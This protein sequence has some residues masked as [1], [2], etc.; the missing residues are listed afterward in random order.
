MATEE[1]VLTMS[2]FGVE[3][4]RISKADRNRSLTPAAVAAGA[5]VGGLA[6]ISAGRTAAT[7]DALQQARA[8]QQDA[9]DIRQMA[10][11]KNRTA[12]E[13]GRRG[14]RFVGIVGENRSAA[15]VLH[16]IARRGDAAAAP[17]L[18]EVK[19]L[20]RISSN[21]AAGGAAIGALGAGIGSALYNHNKKK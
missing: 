19:R 7:R 3:D 13:A 21:R 6:T 2:A 10:A 15:D 9:A 8:H 5:G 16:T 11:G 4:N 20:R 14:P 18:A 12:L 1:A 17:H